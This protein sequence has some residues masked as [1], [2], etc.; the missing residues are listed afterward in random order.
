MFFCCF[1]FSKLAHKTILLVSISQT[2][3]MYQVRFLPSS[4]ISITFKLKS[5]ILS[6][7]CLTL[8]MYCPHFCLLGHNLTYLVTHI[9]LYQLIANDDWGENNSTCD[10][11]LDIQDWPESS[12]NMKF[13]EIGASIIRWDFGKLYN[14]FWLSFVK[15]DI[16]SVQFNLPHENTNKL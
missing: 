3:I 1:L 8:C 5:D 9:I 4:V 16:M 11:V 15:L 7:P 14:T 10:L 12:Y 2:Q 13:K 6:L